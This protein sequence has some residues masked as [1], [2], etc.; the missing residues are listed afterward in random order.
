MPGIATKFVVLISLSIRIW[1]VRFRKSEQIQ[2]SHQITEHSLC[3]RHSL[4]GARTLARQTSPAPFDS[5]KE[6]LERW[7]HTSQS[8]NKYW[9]CYGGRRWCGC[10]GD[11]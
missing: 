1:A 10:G 8:G 7:E 5:P 9:R 11:P 6:A 4:E 3:V 2:L